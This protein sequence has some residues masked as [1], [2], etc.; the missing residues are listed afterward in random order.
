MCL[1]GESPGGGI[2]NDSGPEAETG[3][4]CRRA[5]RRLTQGQGREPGASRDQRS[6]AAP[7]AG[8][9]MGA[10][11]HL[12]DSVGPSRAGGKA[13]PVLPALETPGPAGGRHQADGQS[14]LSTWSCH[15]VPT[16]SD[17]K[18]VHRAGG[19]AHRA[20]C[21]HGELWSPWSQALILHHAW[22]MPSSALSAS[23][24]PTPRNCHSNS[25]CLWI[26][27]SNIYDWFLSSGL[28]SSIPPPP[29][30]LPLEHAEA[31]LSPHSDHGAVSLA[32]LLLSGDLTA[33]FIGCAFLDE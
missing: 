24:I 21:G 6:R 32:T 16:H 1:P 13:G 7:S 2:G 18:S 30:P 11:L 17:P 19:L 12:P 27:A 9:K 28:G 20:P 14:A 5:A 10:G 25:L 3:Q 8:R 26:R 29:P 4:V 31:A 33:L 22:H 15:H 23:R